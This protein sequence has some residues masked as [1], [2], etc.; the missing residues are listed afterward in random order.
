MARFALIL[1][2]LLVAPALAQQPEPSGVA[3]S[4]ETQD[5]GISIEAPHTFFVNVTHTGGFS[6]PGFEQTRMFHVA[7]MGT[8]DGWTAAVEPSNFR[9]APGQTQQVEIEVAASPGAPVEAQNS[10]TVLAQLVP[11]GADQVPAVGP[12]ADP[13]AEATA[14]LSFTREDPLGREVRE[15]L[16]NWIYVFVL[17]FVA[18]VVLSTK[19]VIDRQRALVA[20]DCTTPELQLA[21]GGRGSFRILVTNKGPRADTI[22]FHLDDVEDGWAAFLPVPELSI[23]AD[24]VQELELIVI[25]PEG[26]APGARQSILVTAAAGQGP[27]KPSTLTVEAVVA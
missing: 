5:A 25:A 11:Q 8:P 19:L 6:A 7:L 20:L 16:G 18:A 14:T 22:V 2:V 15:V 21:P 1:L 9:L 13:D 10:I 23:P 17:A 12:V 26:A 4:P 27:N 24:H 3:I